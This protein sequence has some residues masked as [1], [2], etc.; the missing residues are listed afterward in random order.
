MRIGTGHNVDR[1]ILRFSQNFGMKLAGALDRNQSV[2][3]LS[4]LDESR[5][6]SAY[7]PGWDHCDIWLE[8]CGS[9]HSQGWRI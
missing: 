5:K 8:F 1:F 3:N 4:G 2:R 6:N 9:L 7:I